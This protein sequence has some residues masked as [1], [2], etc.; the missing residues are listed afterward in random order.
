M[1]E[2]QDEFDTY[3]VRELT[4]IELKALERAIQPFFEK[5]TLKNGEEINVLNTEAYYVSKGAKTRTGAVV[6]E[7][8]GKEYTT[9]RYAFLS[10]AL[11][12]LFGTYAR[13]EY[14]QMKEAQELEDSMGYSG[15]EGEGERVG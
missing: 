5:V 10:A 12:Q 15:A 8:V 11:S 1:N 2:T 3:A 6:L 4:P 7:T 9:P 13:R 14:A